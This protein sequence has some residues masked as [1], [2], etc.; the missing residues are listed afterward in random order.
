MI[1]MFSAERRGLEGTVLAARSRSATK[2]WPS[3]DRDSRP[4]NLSLETLPCHLLGTLSV[5]TFPS[6]PPPSPG[7]PSPDTIATTYPLSLVQH[8]TCLAQ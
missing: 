4:A 3:H 6:Y 5:P 1:V 2:S 8:S 7:P